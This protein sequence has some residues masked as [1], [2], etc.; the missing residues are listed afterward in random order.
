MTKE[1]VFQ[2]TKRR[3]SPRF[4]RRLADFTAKLVSISSL[5]LAVALYIG[6]AVLTICAAG[7]MEMPAAGE[8]TLRQALTSELLLVTPAYLAMRF[9]PFRWL[10]LPCSLYLGCATGA[11]LAVSGLNSVRHLGLFVIR[12]LLV[13]AMRGGNLQF[14]ALNAAGAVLKH[15]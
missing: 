9:R 7:A 11:Y 2:G 13:P 8:L 14:A 5:L 12:L 15:L 4:L 1:T 6:A 10:R 3:D